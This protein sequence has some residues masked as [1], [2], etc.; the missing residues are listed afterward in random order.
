MESGRV[1]WPLQDPVLG[2]DTEAELRSSLQRAEGG[3][4]RVELQCAA[5]FAG[6]EHAVDDAGRKGV[7]DHAV[8]HVELVKTELFVCEG[9]EV[10]EGLC[11]VCWVEDEGDEGL[12][13]QQRGVVED[14]ESALDLL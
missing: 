9:L 3:K 8:G 1:S 12:G 10:L 7:A 13:R 4:L 11:T 2:G 5:A 14:S 6:D